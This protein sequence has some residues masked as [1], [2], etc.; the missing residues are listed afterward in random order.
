MRI[1]FN[2][3]E[4]GD[5]SL[6]RVTSID[7]LDS[8]PDLSIGIAPKPRRHGSWL[9]GKLAQKRVI[10]MNFDILGDPDNE[11]LTTRPKNALAKA[12]QIMDEEL[13]LIFDMGYGEDSV[14]VMASVTALDL[15]IGQNYTRF[16]SGT[17]EFTC[18]DP[19]KY[20]TATRKGTARVP[21]VPVATPYGAAYGFPYSI[22]TGLS[23]TFKATNDGNTPAP[24]VYKVRGPVTRPIIMLDDSA[25]GN[26][27]TK[28][29]L[30][31]KAKDE[32]V[33]D[34]AKN[35][36]LVNGED[37][38]GFATGA[39]VAD[40]TLRPGTTTVS[41]RGSNTGGDT[42]PSLTATWRDTSR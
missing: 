41:F 1:A 39:L 2:G 6:Y 15:P 10:T 27:T 19:H 42:A 35:S 11:W 30:T 23:G 9:G 16:R 25:K 8:L 26:R 36:V 37:R 31:L 7:G 21:E 20:A 38:F 18:T 40:L 12:F 33:V 24:V 4:L 14:R 34:T 17:V 29:L 28:F 5:D 3:L 22:T 13:P 32:L